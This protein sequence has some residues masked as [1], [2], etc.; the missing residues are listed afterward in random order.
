[1]QKQGWQV[2]L[3]SCTVAEAGG[4]KE[5]IAQVQLTELVGLPLSLCL[6]INSKQPRCPQEQ[7]GQSGH[8]EQQL[9]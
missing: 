8:P 6:W 5:V 4:Y 7:Q 3:L 1:M 9:R 2:N